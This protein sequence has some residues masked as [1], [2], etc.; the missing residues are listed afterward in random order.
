[1][2]T[3][4]TTSLNKCNAIPSAIS[5]DLNYYSVKLSAKS[6]SDITKYNGVRLTGATSGVVATCIDTSATDG[7]DLDTFS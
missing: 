1:M 4:L 7:T 3:Y 2:K 5:Y 6:V